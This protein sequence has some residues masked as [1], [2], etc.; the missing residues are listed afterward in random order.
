MKKKKVGYEIT[1]VFVLFQGFLAPTLFRGSYVAKENI[2]LL[3][4]ELLFLYKP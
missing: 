4:E 2:F 3:N 1:V